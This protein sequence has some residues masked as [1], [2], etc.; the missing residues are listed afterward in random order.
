MVLVASFDAGTKGFYSKGLLYRLEP[1]GVISR[2]SLEVSFLWDTGTGKSMISERV[3]K[4]LNIRVFDGMPVLGVGGTASSGDCAVAFVIPNSDKSA[5]W[6]H[7][8]IVG[9]FP[10]ENVPDVDVI[11]G[12][13]VILEGRM[14]IEKTGGIPT[15]TF[16]VPDP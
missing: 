6:I 2:E 8:V 13:D 1:G 9:T 14:I 3:C 15:L 7:P 5:V 12:L 11:I 10:T 4:A 16:T